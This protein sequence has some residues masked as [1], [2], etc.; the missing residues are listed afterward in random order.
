MDPISD[1]ITKIS[2]DIINEYQPITEKH[3][4]YQ[5][6]YTSENRVKKYSFQGLGDYIRGTIH[7]YQFIKQNKKDILLKVN[8]SN[9]VLNHF[10]VCDNH[11]TVKTCEEDVKYIFQVPLGNRLENNYIFTNNLLLS[12]HIDQDCKDFIIKNCLTPRMDF[13]N[14]VTL[15]KQR[16]HIEDYAYSMIHI[17]THDDEQLN[18]S[19]LDKII[20]IIQFITRIEENKNTKF[21][22]IANND[23]YLEYINFSSIQHTHLKKAHLG[24]PQSNIENAQDTMI[25]FMLASTSKKIYQLSVYGW[26]SGFSD[27][28]R[29]VY[30][31]PIEHF[32]IY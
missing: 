8:F 18:Q 5:V 27:T 19:R 32:S 28:I 12:N 3:I 4:V 13:M 29:N 17:R 26:G 31:V 30:S 2:D 16:L 9:H 20:K 10:F 1:F 25:E 14:K 24:M 23:I 22:L 11:L 6:Y 21:L 15:T 7:L